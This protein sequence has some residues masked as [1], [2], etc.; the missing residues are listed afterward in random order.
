MISYYPGRRCN[1]SVHC[2]CVSLYLL[3]VESLCPASDLCAYYGR[4]G[5]GS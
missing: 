5:S 1:P 2:Y 3:W 4:S